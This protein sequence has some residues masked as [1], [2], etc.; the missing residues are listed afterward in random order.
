VFEERSRS[1]IA[2]RRMCRDIMS[3]NV[4]IAREVCGRLAISV[5][6]WSWVSAK[7][8]ILIDSLA[9]SGL[10]TVADAIEEQ[11]ACVVECESSSC[12]PS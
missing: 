3:V 10:T 4:R 5:V 2:V 1:G 11:H 6:R 9:Y 7:F 8:R 12:A